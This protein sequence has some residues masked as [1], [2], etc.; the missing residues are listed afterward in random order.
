[1]SLSKHSPVGLASDYNCDDDDLQS[2][3]NDEVTG[4]VSQAPTLTQILKTLHGLV[5]GQ[6]TLASQQTA[7]HSTQALNMDQQSADYTGLQAVLYIGR[8]R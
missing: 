3:G 2:R 1:M 4:A 6:S 8:I 7:L 5:S